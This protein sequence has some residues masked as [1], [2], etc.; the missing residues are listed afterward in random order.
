[1]SNSNHN[2]SHDLATSPDGN[3]PLRLIGDPIEPHDAGKPS[4]RYTPSDDD[5]RHLIHAAILGHSYSRLDRADYE[6]A[7]SVSRQARSID[8]NDENWLRAQ[9]ASCR[10]IG[11]DPQEFFKTEIAENPNLD[12]HAVDHGRRPK[13]YNVWGDPKSLDDAGVK[14]SLPSEI[15]FMIRWADGVNGKNAQFIQ[16]KRFTR[17]FWIA[18]VRRAS[19]TVISLFGQKAFDE[20]LVHFEF[21]EMLRSYPAFEF[22]TNGLLPNIRRR[23]RIDRPRRRPTR[24]SRG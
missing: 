22:R 4:T 18:S 2:M 9:I 16:D 10:A 24:R 5:F 1:M 7:G 8:S 14:F 6:H 15:Y 12:R 3:P 13:C 17:E 23:N 21:Q 20:L 19:R 11:Q